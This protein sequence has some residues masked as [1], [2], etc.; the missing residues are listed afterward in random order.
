MCP[1]AQYPP[2]GHDGLEEVANDVG[3]AI[4]IEYASIVERGD[5]LGAQKRKGAGKP[6]VRRVDDDNIRELPS[7]RTE[8]CFRV[9]VVH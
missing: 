9:Y 7:A 4:Q 8:D 5:E 2:D 3:H 6:E 1:V